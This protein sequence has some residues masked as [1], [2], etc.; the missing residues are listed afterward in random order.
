MCEAAKSEETERNRR[1]REV[2]TLTETV[3]SSLKHFLNELA[4]IDSSTP[5]RDKSGKRMLYVT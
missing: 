2:G 5:R 4:L 3:A 1:E